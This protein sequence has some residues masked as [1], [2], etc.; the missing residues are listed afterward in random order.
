MS[1]C[2]FPAPFL[3][4]KR[5]RPFI[6]SSV[7]CLSVTYFPTLSHKRRD[8]RKKKVTEPKMCDIDIVRT[9]QMHNTR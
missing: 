8:F 3:L 4:K 1:V 9:E 2:I 5:L 7:V 6:L